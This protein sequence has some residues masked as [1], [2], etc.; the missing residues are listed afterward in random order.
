MRADK[1][2]RLGEAMTTLASRDRLL[3]IA[4]DL[5][6]EADDLDADVVRSAASPSAD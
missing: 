3:Q 6:A 5:R 2:Q 1:A 4:R